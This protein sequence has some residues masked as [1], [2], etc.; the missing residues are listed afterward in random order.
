MPASYGGDGAPTH[1]VHR[2]QSG[3]AVAPEAVEPLSYRPF[4]QN[5]A[6]QEET[7]RQP[8]GIAPVPRITIHAFCESHDVLSVLEKASADRIMSRARTDIFAGGIKAAVEFYRH[9]SAPNLLVVERKAPNDVVL[10]ELEELAELCDPG[11]KVLVIGYSNEIGFYRELLRRGVSEYVIAPVDAISLV[12]T[13]SGIYRDASSGKL[14]QIYAFV[15]T[16]GGV[17]SSTVAHNVGWSLARRLGSDVIL[18]DLDLPFGTA[19]LNL[20]VDTHQGI[21][22]AIQ[23][24][25]RLDE[26]LLDRLLTKCDD[27]FSLLA[28]PGTLETPYDLD[29]DAFAGLLEIAQANVPFT[30]LDIPHLWTSWARNALVAADEVVITAAPDLANLRNA[31]GLV[32]FLKQARPHDAPPWL[33]L[34]Q[35]GMTKRPE[36]KPSEFARPLGIEPL[37]SVPF[38]AALFGTAANNGRMIADSAPKSAAAQSFADIAAAIAGRKEPAKRRAGFPNLRA[39]LDGMK[40]KS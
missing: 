33:V 3:I 2:R 9:N 12:A 27:H 15:G 24:S 28:S 16:K 10:A 30:I 38:D 13:V 21:A 35:V 8:R 7:V 17:G 20:N 5:E 36:I 39:L 18:A 4:Q 26:V 40:R 6:V 23:D 29:A 32:D 34:N 31:K 37:A 14:G 1:H 22:E 11:T 25:S 19:G